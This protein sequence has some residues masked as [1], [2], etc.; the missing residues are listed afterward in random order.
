MNVYVI[1]VA[2]AKLSLEKAQ[3]LTEVKDRDIMEVGWKGNHTLLFERDQG[4][5]ENIHLFAIDLDTQKTR[6][7]TPF[8]GV[9]AEIVDAL[10]Q[11]DEDHIL[12]ALN[13]RKKEVFDVY[14]LNVK[15]GEMKL[16][17]DNPGNF[18]SWLTDH[19]GHIR[20]AIS[21]DGVN[22]SLYYREN[23]SV[24]FRKT[25]TTD[26]RTSIEPLFFTFDNRY[27][28]ASSNLKRDKS[29]LVIFDLRRGREKKKIFEHPDVD[30]HTLS[31]SRQRKT[32]I[33]ANYTTWKHERTFFDKQTETVFNDVSALLKGYEVGIS[34]FDQAETR[35]I[36]RTY[37]DRSRGAVYLYDRMTHELTKLRDVS[38]WLNEN[39]LAEM[40]PISYRSRDGLTIN[41]Y[42]T[43]PKGYKTGA[44]PFV[45]NPHGGPWARDEWGFN[46]EVQL[47]AN[48]GYGVLQM[49]Y[50]G[51]TGYGRAFWEASFKQWGKKMQDD[52]SDGVRWLV[53][54][55]YADANHICIYGGS[56]GGYAVLAGLAFTPELYACGVD[57]VGVSNLFTFYKGIPSYWKPL[58]QMTYEMV[59]DPKKDEALL[60]SASPIFHVDQIRAPLFVAQG[61]ND[62]RVNINESNQI[63]EALKKRGVDVP[64]MVKANEGHGFHNEENRFDFYDHMIAFL[65]KY[66]DA[67]SP[68]ESGH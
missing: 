7:L 68:G 15:T 24:R 41:G 49:N 2:E 19:K 35:Y 37:S 38:P 28:Y 32:L 65:G 21:T 50:R 45:I 34:G 26:F 13:Q 33:A 67:K 60:R 66:L 51:S 14:Q 30:V 17:A 27:V 43:L 64:Y 10:D 12:I 54:K 63:V 5:D 25:L 46:P 48:H 3:R 55:Q 16:V 4:G 56:Y 6:E 1:S 40:K 8:Q 39:T 22:T 18:T 44:I 58:L 62:P 47:L 42:L 11:I 52:I 9:R 20:G 29:A 23:E 36:I 59:G 31:Y 53:A 57:Y 61:A